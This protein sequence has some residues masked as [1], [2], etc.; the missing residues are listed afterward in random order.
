MLNSASEFLQNGDINYSSIVAGHDSVEKS[1]FTY[2][3]GYLWQ[4]TELN[5]LPRHG[6]SF[7]GSDI[8]TIASSSSPRSY[9]SEPSGHYEPFKTDTVGSSSIE[10]WIGNEAQFCELLVSA[11]EYDGSSDFVALNSSVAHPSLLGSSVELLESQSDGFTGSFVHPYTIVDSTEI[12]YRF[13]S[14]PSYSFM[15]ST[16]NSSQLYT[17]SSI[18][19]PSGQPSPQIHAQQQSDNS[20]SHGE[21]N[22]L[23]I[24]STSRRQYAER[25]H[26]TAS[27]GIPPDTQMPLTTGAQAQRADE[28]KI[29]LEEKQK[30]LTYKEIRKKMRT[31]VAESTLRGRY[32]SLTKERKDRVRKPV[33]TPKDVSAKIH[34]RRVQG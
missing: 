11:H 12:P 10:P 1:D 8:D 30:G 27:M 29:L 9:F 33:W 19:M 4:P 31:L 5:G 28:D 15:G 20:I 25:V 16:S 23:A 17:P 32:R 34:C 21:N 24:C 14:D 22:I 3:G 13:P 2:G 26:S 18:M 6:F 7:D